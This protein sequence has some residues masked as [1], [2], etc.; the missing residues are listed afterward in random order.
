MYNYNNVL[1]LLLSELDV[2]LN[3]QVTSD[4][5]EECGAF[6]SND[7]FP[8]P[9]HTSSAL[10]LATACAAYLAPQSPVRAR[11]EL[12]ERIL[13]AISFQLKWQHDSGLIDLPK[14]TPHS[15]PDTAFSVQ[16]LAPFA[17][18]AR[19]EE[20]AST[21]QA[22][23]IA[24]RL[25]DY[26]LRAAHGIIGRGFRTPN[27]RWVVV[28]AL[29]QAVS[30]FP[31]L[32]EDALPY[33][34]SILAETIDINE[35][36]EYSERST[37][38]YT[39]VCNRSLR[40][41]ADHLNRPE[42]L[43]H[44]RRNL[45]FTMSLL[46]DDATIVTSISHRQDAGAK[47]VP[48]SMADSFFDLAHRDGNGR[49][50]SV[51]DALVRQFGAARQVCRSG[52]AH[53]IVPFLMDPSL[54]TAALERTPPPEKFQH[55][56]PQSRLWCVKDRQ[57][58]ATASAGTAMPFSLS[59]RD[60]ELAAVRIR[61]GYFHQADFEATSI[62]KTER[63][64]RLRRHN[65]REP[66]WDLPVG[67]PVKFR[68]PSEYYAFATAERE[69]WPLPPL[70]LILEIDRLE[71]GFDLHFQTD[72]GVARTAFRVEFCF[73]GTGYWE[74]AAQL[75]PA[76]P[77]GSAWLKAGTGYFHNHREAISVEGGSDV[78]RLGFEQLETRP[79]DDLF[80]VGIPMVSPVSETFQIRCGDWSMESRQLLAPDEGRDRLHDLLER[81]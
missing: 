51:A 21:P 14:V 27:H 38:V 9:D 48:I 2:T 41:A 67:R 4:Q 78:H 54:R 3:R 33:V 65:E 56:F 1:L 40:Y 35:D 69:R 44:V 50:A 66:G 46:R 45:D 53:L 17:E 28:S 19:S 62:E 72:G 76:L 73:S 52:Y 18:Y 34:E 36:G 79:R 39:A 42:L 12:A 26:L 31:E 37:G 22:E 64:V 15:P 71:N 32:S 5:K 16:L 20:A 43:E 47:V 81:K 10:Q 23:Q 25:G 70:H 29:A 55:F 63:G 6:L 13:A 77:G 57:L 8:S 59:F 30:L 61:G 74:T 80:V 24:E 11:P 49:W 58:L 60:L 75:A 68:Q 7:Y